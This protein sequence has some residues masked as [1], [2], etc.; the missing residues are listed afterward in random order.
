MY[1]FSDVY[2]ID[3]ETWMRNSPRYESIDGVETDELKKGKYSIINESQQKSNALFPSLIDVAS[4]ATI[5]ANATC[6]TT[7]DGSDETYCRLGNALQCGVC[8][9][10]MSEKR[11]PISYATDSEL[12][13]WWQSPTLEQG[14]EYE[15]VAITM[16]LKQVD[17]I[18]KSF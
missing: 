14:S 9:D 1:L 10:I 7:G 18:Y 6:G 15:H 2:D 3:N 8:N 17:L 16:D 12:S 13:T 4:S 11:H 5:T